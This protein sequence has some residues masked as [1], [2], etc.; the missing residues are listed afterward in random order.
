[1]LSRVQIERPETVE[2]TERLLREAIRL[3]L[4]GMQADGLPI[5]FLDSVLRNLVRAADPPA[6]EPVQA[7][8]I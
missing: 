5:T 3:H 2:E 7:D 4:N 8:L 6:F 1:L